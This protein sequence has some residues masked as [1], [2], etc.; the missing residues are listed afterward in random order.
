VSTTLGNKFS[1]PLLR[2]GGVFSSVFGKVSEIHLGVQGRCFIV[3]Q[4]MLLLAFFLKDA[5]QS[6][7]FVVGGW[8]DLAQSPSAAV[9]VV[10]ESKFGS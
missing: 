9:V 3:F 2:P 10:G 8:P 7:R 5:L 6:I 4:V 1:R